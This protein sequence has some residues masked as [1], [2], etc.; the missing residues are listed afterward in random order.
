MEQHIDKMDSVVYYIIKARHNLATTYNW[1]VEDEENKVSH[2]KN[3][4]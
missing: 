1:A 2:N 3:V 4:F